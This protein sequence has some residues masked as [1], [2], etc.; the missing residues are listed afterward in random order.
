MKLQKQTV[1]ILALIS[2][3]TA[4]VIVIALIASPM[5]PAD[6]ASNTVAATTFPIYD[7]TRQVAGDDVQ[8]ELILPAG[9]SP[10]TFEP[11]PADLRLLQGTSVVYTNGLA[12]DDWS[13]TISESLGAERKE[14]CPGQMLLEEEEGDED[15]HDDEEED[16]E[17]EHGSIDPHCWLSVANAKGIATD[18]ADDLSL[19]FP[20]HA[21]QFQANLQTYLQALDETD[22]KIFSALSSIENRQL[23]TFHNSFAYFARDYDLE[24]IGTFE[25]TAGREPTSQDLIQ[26]THAIEDAGVTT[27]YSEPQLSTAPLQAFLEDNNVSVAVLDPLGGVETRTSYIDL[28]LYN[29]EIISQNQ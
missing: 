1:S 18:I 8:V 4:L 29:A 17:H 28:M 11:S 13:H 3:V 20:E 5:N 2:S 22:E 15:H 16:H 6:T 9:A 21:A 7:I 10:H 19:R 12:L 27:I 26:L 25:P 24:V 14:L 23:V